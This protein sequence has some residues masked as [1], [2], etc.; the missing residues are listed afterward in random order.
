[1]GPWWVPWH[2]MGGT[3][4]TPAAT[5]ATALHGSLKACHG[6]PH[7]NP[8]PT[9]PRLGLGLRLGLGFHGMPWKMPSKVL[10]QLVARHATA[11]RAK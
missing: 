6:N 10:P 2:A 1:M 4:A 7:G 9:A 8:M 5:A 3:V 11:H